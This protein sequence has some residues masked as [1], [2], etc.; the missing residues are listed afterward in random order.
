MN[1]KALNIKAMIKTLLLRKFT[2]GLLLLQLSITLGLVV[3]TVLMSMETREKLN[4]PMDFDYKNLIAVRL[5]PTSGEFRDVPFYLE[6]LKEDIRRLS[7]ID[8][9]ISAAHYNQLPIQN[10][11]W[12][13]SVK[14][15]ELPED[16][17]LADDL[18][19]VP[20]FLSSEIGLDNLGLEIIEGRNLTKADDLTDLFYSP[21]ITDEERSELVENIV[22]TE[23]LAKAVFPD[24]P[25]LGKMTNIGLVVGVARDFLVNPKWNPDR[26]RYFATFS[27]FT[28]SRADNPQHYMIRVEPGKLKEVLDQVEATILDVNSE[29]FFIELYSLEERLRQFYSEETGLS[30]LFTTLSIL[31]LLVTVISSFAHA[32]FHVSQQRKFIG[33]RRAL[34]ARRKD[35][36]LYIFTENWLITTIACLLGIGSTVGINMLLGQSIDISKPDVS[37]YLLTVVVIFV[38]GSLATWLPAYKTTRIAPVIATR[39]I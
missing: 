6:T 34:G 33:I 14:D 3:N 2:T 13:S 36:M 17:I 27:N 28:F 19:Y 11:G 35:I 5:L 18:S 23:S 21:G 10:G 38:S 1:I 24:K 26:S 9:V 25:A 12:N 31:M 8:G 20:N 32:H 30:H 39:T 7:A 15:A 37:L 4:E 16:A 29:R 22:I